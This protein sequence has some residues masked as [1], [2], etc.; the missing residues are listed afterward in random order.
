VTRRRTLLTLACALALLFAWSASTHKVT[1][2]DVAI[3]TR[4]ARPAPPPSAR[5][6]P[7][8]RVTSA[9][10]ADPVK[11]GI[12]ACDDYVA[13]MIACDQLPDDAKI[14]IAEASKAWA[15]TDERAALEDSCRATASVQGDS[16][17]AI[18]C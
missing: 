12:A 16:L 14:A 10:P 9:P 13:R 6:A 4:H 5:R 1:P 2:G 8:P 18:G 7:S 17:A 11:T 15:E 3:A